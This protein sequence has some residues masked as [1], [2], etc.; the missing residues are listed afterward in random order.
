[1]DGLLTFSFVLMAATIVENVIANI[2]STQVSNEAANRVEIL[3]RV[4]FPLV[5]FVGIALM[6]FGFGLLN[7]GS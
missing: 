3:S 7:F 6:V 4:L 5:Y 2:L 1:M